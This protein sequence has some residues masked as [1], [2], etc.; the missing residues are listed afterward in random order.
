M[1]PDRVYI[2][3]GKKYEEHN[4]DGKLDTYFIT[5]KTSKR[6]IMNGYSADGELFSTVTA[7]YN[8]FDQVYKNEIWVARKDSPD[9]YES[10][11][12][13]HLSVFGEMKPIL[14]DYEEE[15]REYREIPIQ[16]IK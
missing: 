11:L 12:V 9:Y 2:K 3:D 14:H 5:E 15:E 7:Y 1:E 6:L 13:P 16:I 4:V 10:K 8:R